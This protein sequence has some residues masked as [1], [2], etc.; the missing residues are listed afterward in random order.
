MMLAFF[1]EAFAEPKMQP[2]PVPARPVYGDDRRLK[3]V[4]VLVVLVDSFIH[5]EPT[6]AIRTSITHPDSPTNRLAGIIM[7]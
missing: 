5:C 2:S 1:F 4:R 7:S 6:M 3:T